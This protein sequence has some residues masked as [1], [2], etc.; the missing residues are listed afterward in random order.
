MYGVDLY[1]KKYFSK[2]EIWASYTLSQTKEYF[3]YFPDYEYSNA[4]QDQRH[5]IKGALLLNFN[6][7]FFSV[8]Y[9]YGSGFPDRP[10]FFNQDYERYPYSRLDAALIYRHSVKDYH[11]E[12]GLSILNLLNTENIKYSNFIRI[13][14]A[15]SGSITVHAEAVPFT[16]TIY[17]NI[18]F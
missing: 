3:P 12:V 15:Q 7:L 2:H 17:L 13:P 5:E 9:V 1:A 4:P 16:P 11:F 6:P 18:S 14:N 8:N 10:T